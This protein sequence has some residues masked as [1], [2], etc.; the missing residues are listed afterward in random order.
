MREFA[1][2]SPQFW[3]GPLSKKIKSCNFEAKTLAFYLMTCP[4]SNMIG[5]YYLPLS[6]MAHEIGTTF[7]IVSKSMETLIQAGFCAYDQETDYVWVYEM[8]LTQ[9]GATLKPKDNKVKHVNELF[10]ALPEIPFLN[11][12]YEKYHALLHLDSRE[13]ASKPFVIPLEASKK[14]EVRSEKREVISNKENIPI[15]FSTEHKKSTTKE[16]QNTDDEKSISTPITTD[17]DPPIFMVPLRQGKQHPITEAELETWGKNYPAV[18]VRQEIRH[19]MEWNKAN[20]D[21]QKTQRGINRHIQG[22]LAHTQQNQSKG[23]RD[24]PRQAVSTWDHNVAV[25]RDVL[26]E[27]DGN[28]R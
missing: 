15:I 11:G 8:A 18:D 19:L 27:E 13:P 22:W 17:I 1:K 20:P 25:I 2:F 14:K 7:E 12:F 5:F 21:R 9:V 10:Q 3:M 24:S 4:N 28:Q 16:T 26:E 6:L 23:N